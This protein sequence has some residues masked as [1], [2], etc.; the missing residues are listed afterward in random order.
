MQSNDINFNPSNE[1]SLDEIKVISDSGRLEQ[2]QDLSG[3]SVKQLDKSL[4][5]VENLKFIKRTLYWFVLSLGAISW[6]YTLGS[7]AYYWGF[8]MKAD[9]EL[10]RSMTIPSNLH[11]QVLSRQDNTLVPAGNPLV[12]V[13]SPGKYDLIAKMQNQSSNFQALVEYKFLVNGTTTRTEVTFV[14]PSEEKY[15]S[16]LGYES[17]EPVN[18]TQL[19]IVSLRWQRINKH[20]IPNWID[21]RQ[22][23]LN[24]AISGAKYLSSRDSG[25]TDKIGIGSAEFTIANNTP[26]NYYR[27]PLDVYLYSMNEVVAVARENVDLFYSGETRNVRI[28]IA[29]S[30]NQVDRVEVQPNINI[31]NNDIYIKF[32]GGGVSGQ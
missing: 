31:I 14:N 19:Q 6:M 27:L 25:L 8:G 29:G 17:A 4:W 7:F 10:L 12:L 23:H 1:K 3:V 28:N 30:F 15:L 11:N 22:N 16:N 5:W 32:K 26:F 2:Y 21:F 20:D 24:F 13:S 9:N 18:S